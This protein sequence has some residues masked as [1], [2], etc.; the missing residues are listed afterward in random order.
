[1]QVDSLLSF[2][3]PLGSAYTGSWTGRAEL[4]ITIGG[5]ST[6]VGQFPT[7]GDLTVTVSPLAF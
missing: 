1:M 2:S 6:A 5:A 7:I 3:Q 4:V